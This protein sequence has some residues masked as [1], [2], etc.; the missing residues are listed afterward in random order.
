M[1]WSN[2]FCFPLELVNFPLAPVRVDMDSALYSLYDIHWSEILGGSE[3]TSQT[4]FI[5]KDSR[6]VPQD[7]FTTFLS[8]DCINISLASSEFPHLC[9]YLHVFKKWTLMFFNTLRSRESKVMFPIRVLFSFP[10]R[11]LRPFLSRDI[12]SFP[13]CS[14]VRHFLPWER[15][16][17]EA[18]PQLRRTPQWARTDS[19]G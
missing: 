17:C 14:S 1:V 18:D 9:K 3:F 4:S 16:S 11:M 19:W 13:V 6:A 7:P 12:F 2:F 10:V 8:V 15:H 5:Q